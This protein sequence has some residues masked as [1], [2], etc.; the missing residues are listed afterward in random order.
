[1]D[2]KHGLD[3]VLPVIDLKRGQVVHAIA[4][5]REQY[6]PLRS[7]IVDSIH[8]GRVAKAVC[9]YVACRDLYVADLDAIAGHAPD[10]N[11]YAAIENAGAEIWLDAGVKIAGL[12]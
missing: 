9:E 1:M 6:A 3:H 7:Q 2:A 4:G 8:P 12:C 10:Y 11:S 5:N